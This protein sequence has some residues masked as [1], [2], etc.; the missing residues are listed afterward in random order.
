MKK[1][2]SCLFSIA[3]MTSLFINVKAENVSKSD[4]DAT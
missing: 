3:L 1:I 4:S 2:A